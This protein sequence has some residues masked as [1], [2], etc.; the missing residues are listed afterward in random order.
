M[1]RHHQHPR[2]TRGP[3]TWR[4]FG[5]AAGLL[6]LACLLRPEAA[7]APVVAESSALTGRGMFFGA[8]A[9]KGTILGHTEALPPRLASCANC[10]LDEA[11]LG[12]SASFGP[13]L[14]RQGMTHLRGRRGGPPSLFSP[15][16]FCRLL[17]TGVDPAYV[18]ITRQ[19]PRYTLSDEQRLGLWRYLMET[20]DGPNDE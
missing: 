15:T 9:L 7:S 14:N 5:R 19:M 18:L 16:S 11:G 1:S 20:S 8:D 10:H 13:P 4:F 12:S 2:Q 17:R 6:L 3:A